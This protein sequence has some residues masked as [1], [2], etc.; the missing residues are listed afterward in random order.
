MQDFER[1]GVFY[2]G[3]EYDLATRRPTDELLL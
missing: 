2:L 1:L 3:R